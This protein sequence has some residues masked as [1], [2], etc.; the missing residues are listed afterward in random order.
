MEEKFIKWF[1]K[2]IPVLVEKGIITSQTAHSLNEYYYKKLEILEQPAKAPAATQEETV[3]KQ[4]A[5]PEVKLDPAF[6]EFSVNLDTEKERKEAPEKEAV[7]ANSA[8]SGKAPLSKP[9]V[10]VSVILT[11]IA[12]VLI[13]T[14][15]I[16]LIAYN[17]AAIPRLAKAITAII[18]LLATQ[19]TGFILLKSGKAE[20][21]KIRESYSLFWALLFGGI[22]AFVSQIFKFAGNTSSFLF[23]WTISTIVITWLFKAHT[24]YYLSLLLTIIFS[25]SGIDAESYLLVFLLCAALYL[26]ARKAKAKFI[27][28][29]IFSA[30]FFLIFLTET[31]MPAYI[32]N[33][34]F[35]TLICSAGFI[36]LHKNIV[37][38]KNLGIA[39]ICLASLASVYSWKPFSLFSTPA[40]NALRI[41]NIIFT[42]LITLGFLSEGIIIPLI[43]K[44]KDKNI[45]A[46]ENLIYLIP[47]AI[48]L[49]LLFIKKAEIITSEKALVFYKI[50]LCPLSF[51]ILLSSL[52]FV[53]SSI[54]KSNAA[55]I[56]LSFMI[57]EM[58]KLLAEENSYPS[59]FF[60]VTALIIFAL[61]TILWKNA[62]SIEGENKYCLLIARALTAIMLFLIAF[63]V[64]FPGEEKSIFNTSKLPYLIF[65]CYLPAAIFGLF[66][67]V[68]FAKKNLKSF[69]AH[70]DIPVNLLFAAAI[71]AAARDANQ[72]QIQLL[73]NIWIATNF[74]YS[75]IAAI[76]AEKYSLLIYSA[77]AL[78]Y[79]CASYIKLE[80]TIS[81]M[82]FFCSLMLFAAGLFL[83]KT[84][85]SLT[86]FSKNSLI[87]IRILAVINLFIINL[88]ARN[89]ASVLYENSGI[90]LFML[91]CFTPAAIF[92]L[93]LFCLFAKRNIKDF[94][95]NIDIF[96]NLLV[97][98]VILSLSHIAAKDVIL[99]TL[100]I[101][102]AINLLISCIYII[103]S[104]RYEYAFYTLF[105]IIYFIVVFASLEFSSTILYL[106]ST[107][108]IFVSGTFLWKN[109]FENSDNT[110]TVLLVSKIAGAV[111]LIGTA[112][113]ALDQSPVLFEGSGITNYIVICFTPAA[114]FGLV[115]YGFFAFKNLHSFLYNLDIIINLIFISVAYL[116]A[117]LCTPAAL[118]L[119]L[120]I[121]MILNLAAALIF[122]LLQKKNETTVYFIAGILYFF[123]K[124]G[125]TENSNAA[126]CIFLILALISLFFHYYGQAQNLTALKIL[127]AIMTGLV[128]FYESSLR[129]TIEGD[130]SFISW[131]FYTLAFL[132]LSGLAAIY[133]IT[134]LIRKK[135]LFNPACF[136]APALVLLLTRLEDKISIVA[137]LPLLLLFCV[138]YFYLAYKNDSLKIANLS[139]IYFGLTMMIRFFSAGYG[140]AIQGITFIVTGILLL[141]MNILMTK[142]RE[143][144]E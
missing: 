118:L 80:S 21:T 60:I 77:L 27:P 35:F 47:L 76:K 131:S 5:S 62:F 111:L 85:F 119:A 7:N 29:F 107:S 97:T 137:V 94:L 132:I 12:S 30:I 106:I 51:S 143:R 69:L 139:T 34:I 81:L 82:Y 83:W 2:E 72:N 116:I 121:L 13:S 89:E 31:A 65:F 91:I 117:H 110:K 16:S 11:I 36:F 74:I 105:A 70:L 90:D 113:F 4:P 20:E 66:Q 96:A 101:I 37:W 54:K 25:C 3:E 124:L 127:S 125:F 38:K 140:L 103:R 128:F 57:F 88:L 114:L 43:K 50:F 79:F 134:L 28:L 73:V 120:E 144:N 84:D 68:I 100:Q 93:L 1:I 123:I 6:T 95:L 49:N 9:K 58:L 26:P 15:I 10:S 42:G 33:T 71:Y 56:F 41:V 23:I 67:F 135:I 24:S 45:F 75:V 52:L 99:L 126:A 142:R 92:G 130:L 136:L 40:I 17:W 122:V 104:G 141:V 115:L 138:Y 108:V 18:L 44:I 86:S 87:I 48:V 22:V 55:W 59:I 129:H 102:T 78:A 98:A 53:T 39:L 46:L 14:G 109:N 32:K 61:G 63:A 19:I 8:A 112:V 133:F 64:R